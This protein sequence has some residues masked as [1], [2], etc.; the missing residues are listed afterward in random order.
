MTVVEA[1]DGLAF[2]IAMPNGLMRV[3]NDIEQKPRMSLE[4]RLCTWLSRDPHMF[5]RETSVIHQLPPVVDTTAGIVEPVSEY[6]LAGA[7]QLCSI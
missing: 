7:P 1:R 5:A 6:A 3:Q 4:H 2:S